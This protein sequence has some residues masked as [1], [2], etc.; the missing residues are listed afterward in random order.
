M[1]DYAPTHLP[2]GMPDEEPV[3]SPCISVCAVDRV[4][5]ICMGCLRTLEEIG[6]WRLMTAAEKRAC[7]AACETR[8]K[9]TER[10][11]KD[12]LPLPPPRS[13]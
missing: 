13:T 2:A 3:T 7:V 4:R 6:Q 11:G 10:R 1:P 9:T 8:A 5:G 12:G